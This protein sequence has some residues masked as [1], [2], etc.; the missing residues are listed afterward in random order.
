M[1][2]IL[3]RLDRALAY[4]AAWIVVAVLVAT[5]LSQQGAGW[6]DALVFVVPPFLLYGFVCLSSFYVC[7]AM[8]LATTRPPAVAIVLAVSAIVGG[9]I[10]LTI[11]QAWGVML[12]S[13]SGLESAAAAGASQ[14]PYLFS[15]A[16][17]L[18]LLV[19][20]VHYVALAFEAA[21]N[22]QSPQLELQVL[23]RAAELRALR[24]QINP[25]FLYNSL[26]S[27]SALTSADA[28]GARRMCML[29]ADFLR[30]TL[31]MSALDRI[32]VS[33]EL[34]LVDAFMDIEQVRFRAR[35]RV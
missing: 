3:G 29:F 26:N 20:S 21:R 22:A 4:A 35:L 23:T 9:V 19:L 5:S 18:F 6:F 12:R 30:S 14:Q 16:V 13:V 2:P 34:A 33:E 17:I 28:E 27:I 32:R 15:V 24:A 25:H 7:R 31:K 11:A 10:W 8:P 1:H